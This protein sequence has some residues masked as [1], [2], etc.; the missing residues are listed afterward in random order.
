MVERSSG[1]SVLLSL[2]LLLLPGIRLEVSNGIPAGRTARPDAAPSAP[3]LQD[4]SI[5]EEK[6]LKKGAALLAKHAG[7]C[8]RAGWYSRAKILWREILRDYDPDHQAAR[9]AL[10]FRKVPSGWVLDGVSFP[11]NTVDSAARRRL[12]KDWSRICV[13]L[14]RSHKELGLR[15]RKEGREDRARWHFEK[16]LRFDPTDE[17]LAKLRSLDRFE[18]FY[19]TP[20]E[21]RILRRSRWIRQCLDLVQRLEVPVEELEPTVRQPALAHAFGNGGPEIRGFAT[22]HFRVFGDLD[23]EILREGARNAERALHFCRTIFAGLGGFKIR[24]GEDLDFV[25]FRDRTDWRTLVN[26]C[27]RN[28][29]K[30][31]FT[32]KHLSLVEI[33]RGGRALWASAPGDEEE[34]VNDTVVR[35]VG[36][37][38][39]DLRSLALDEGMG[40][41][42]VGLFF[43]KTLEFLIAPRRE[44]GTRA[45]RKKY[46]PL[47]PDIETWKERAIDQA[48]NKTDVPAAKLPLLKGDELGDE[49]RIKAWYFVEYLLRRDPSLLHALDGRAG[50]RKPRTAVKTTTEV[51]ERFAKLA[52]GLS[53]RRCESE[54]RAYST[55]TGR[56]RSRIEADWN[57]STPVPG[58][59]VERLRRINEIRLGLDLPALAYADTVPSLWKDFCDLNQA[60]PWIREGRLPETVGKALRRYLGM[61]EEFWSKGLPFELRSSAEAQVR[62]LLELPGF[63]DLVLDSRT[64]MVGLH[65]KG[66]IGLFH[67]GERSFGPSSMR[68]FPDPAVTPVR[69]RTGAP[70]LVRPLRERV[71]K[72]MKEAGLDRPK[73]PAGVKRLGPVF[74]LHFFDRPPK[75]PGSL[76]CEARVEGRRLAGLLLRPGD[77][78]DS[79]ICPPGC[80]SF[81]PFLPLKAGDR[82]ELVW[83]F[84]PFEGAQPYEIR[85]SLVIGR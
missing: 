40:H 45:G 79:R 61:G 55:D 82:V 16:A 78:R 76:A 10:G 38:I 43:G 77:S 6:L 84:V 62:E 27:I 19:G 57:P 4:S 74:S 72:A 52:R 69:S 39:A 34:L 20:L 17:D 68:V 3:P 83:S 54:W 33:T 22:K 46:E 47:K 50:R 2:P 29:N 37:K 65:Q 24:K 25:F 30:R 85:R 13:K 35:H 71:W 41:A 58:A 28:A 63:R 49:E 18:S 14:H 9:R 80:V 15:L 12:T 70:V 1:F 75:L 11:K 36:I 44:K 59:L 56:L 66:K 81:V 7:A 73:E 51:E 5:R 67:L 23:P 31:A 64:R 32:L 8:A 42:I 60:G 48:W 53:L 21:I 26:R